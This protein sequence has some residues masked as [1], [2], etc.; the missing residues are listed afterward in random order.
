MAFRSNGSRSLRISRAAIPW[1]LGG[2]SWRRYPRYGTEIGSTQSTRCSPQ[3]GHGEESA[4]LRHAL[5]DRFT[6]L[7]PVQHVRPALR[8]AA[9]CAR[10]VGV[11]EPLAPP[12]GRARH[13]SGTSRWHPR[14]G[15]ASP[16]RPPRSRR[17]RGSPGKPCSAMRIAGSSAS[18]S[19]IVPWASR[20]A[21]HPARAPGTV[22]VSAPERGMVSWPRPTSSARV[23]SAPA[24]PLALS[25]HH[26]LLG[27]Q[28]HD[29]EHVARRSPSS[30]ARPR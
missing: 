10:E 13:R 27:G 17:S 19:E 29:R 16:A 23:I 12:A 5:H 11:A 20:S 21:C 8:D 30:W 6:Q 24:R 7:P 28:P 9:Q 22:I 1:P 15:A 14:P 25:P 3:V 26:A 18:E 2:S 4:Q